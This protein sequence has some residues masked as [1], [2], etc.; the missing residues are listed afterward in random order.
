[1]VFKLL[2]CRTYDG[3]LVEAGSALRI[4]RDKYK[5]ILAR[6]VSKLAQRFTAIGQQ[7]GIQAT[8]NEFSSFFWIGSSKSVFMS[9]RPEDRLQLYTHP[10]RNDSFR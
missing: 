3:R 7:S 9:A 10:L 8:G 1:V 5:V 4:V 6:R 2:Q